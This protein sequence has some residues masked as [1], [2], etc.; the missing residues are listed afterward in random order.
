MIVIATTQMSTIKLKRRVKVTI[1]LGGSLPYTITMEVVYIEVLCTSSKILNR[2]KK[3]QYFLY[4]LDLS[5]NF[6]FPYLCM[7]CEAQAMLGL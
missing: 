7:L 2:S 5:H 4:H 3:S 1:C 6:T